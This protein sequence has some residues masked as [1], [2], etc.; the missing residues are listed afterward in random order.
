MIL[1]SGHGYSAPEMTVIRSAPDNETPLPKSLQGAIMCLGN[2]DGLHLGHQAVLEAAATLAARE[3]RP[4]AIMSCEPHPRSFFAQGGGAPFRLSSPAQKHMRF[5]NAGIDYLFEPQF[6]AAFA[7]Q[8][9]EAFLNDL[10]RARFR[11]GGVVCGGDFRFGAQRAGDTAL[12][13]AFCKSHGL[14]HF[15]VEKSLPASSTGIRA[16][17]VTGDFAA[18]KRQLGE[19]WQIDTHAVGLQLRPQ[20]GRYLARREESHQS[21]EIEIDA[22]GRV[23][24]TG[25]VPL[26]FLRLLGKI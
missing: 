6:D 15:V 19:E 17:L 9:P 16:A 7:G 1:Y 4:L 25:P 8:S 5:R 22:E 10:L 26:R 3:A 20:A 14:S 21:L 18:A 12:L 11:I 24:G 13:I 23:Y 2:F